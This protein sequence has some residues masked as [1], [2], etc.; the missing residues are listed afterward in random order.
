MDT[1]RKFTQA[2]VDYSYA[3]SFNEA[4]RESYEK[5]AHAY[6]TTYIGIN[7]EYFLSELKGSNYFGA[8]LHGRTNELQ[9]SNGEILTTSDISS[10][11]NSSFDKVKVV[12]LTSCSAGMEF[13]DLLRSKGVKVVIGFLGQI[14]QNTA[15]YWTDQLIAS[16]S[17]GN[18]V[19]EALDYA[20]E[21]LKKEFSENDPDYKE[22][23]NLIINGRYTGDSYLDYSPCKDNNL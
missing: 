20:D 23:I 12:I 16:L 11:P 10:I 9:L 21:A 5:N 22:P 3:S 17:E 8:M 15:A 6:G 1:R 7:K 13:V 18:T 4:V 2:T 19:R 14:E